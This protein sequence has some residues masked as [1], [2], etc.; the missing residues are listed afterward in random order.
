M[1]ANCLKGG[2]LSENEQLRC[3]LEWPQEKSE[4][5]QENCGL[6]VEVARV[7]HGDLRANSVSFLRL[8]PSSANRLASRGLEEEIHA[9]DPFGNRVAQ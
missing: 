1:L 7:I 6:G 2:P 4:W 5:R 9:E 3:I 8:D